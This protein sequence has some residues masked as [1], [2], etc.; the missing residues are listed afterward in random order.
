MNLIGL[1]VFLVLLL[2]GPPAALQEYFPVLDPWFQYVW[3]AFWGI[4]FVL[5][6]VAYFFTPPTP[7]EMQKGRVPLSPSL[8][9]EIYLRDGGRC[10]HCGSSSNLQY[11]HIIP[12]SWG[13][14]N[15][16]SNIQLLCAPCNLRKG[17]R[18]VG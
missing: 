8:K 5:G 16:P 13:G 11:D 2:L 14:S 10:R 3:W 15:D 18:Y 6:T 17:N 9:R 1:V 4:I 12:L 7:T